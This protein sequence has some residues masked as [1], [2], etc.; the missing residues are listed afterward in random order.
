MIKEYLVTEGYNE[1]HNEIFQNKE[2]LD[3]IVKLCGSI[4]LSS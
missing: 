1:T 2:S 4:H 3:K